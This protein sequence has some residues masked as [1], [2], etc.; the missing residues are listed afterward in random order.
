METGIIYEQEI[1][2]LLLGCIFKYASSSHIEE[3]LRT[4]SLHFETLDN[5]ND[6]YESDY[7][8]T[9][10]FHS[11]ED[12]KALLDGP[13]TPFG[14][15]KSKIDTYLSSLLV[16]CFSRSAFNSLM[17]SHYTNNHHGIC[18]AIDFTANEIPFTAPEMSWGNV[19]YSTHIP[20]IAIFQDNTTEGTL[21]ASLADIVLTKSSDWS[22]EQEVRFFLRDNTNMQPFKP[23]TLKAVIIGRRTSDDEI[24]QISAIVDDFN[25]R[26]KTSVRVL[27]SMRVAST[28]KVGV[29]SNQGSREGGF[30]ARIPV[31]SDILSPVITTNPNNTGDEQD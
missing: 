3:S 25:N 15:I 2:E 8:I 19:Q 6:I 26:N 1:R 22:Y 28:Y 29:C 16:T 24:A 18:Y 14:N 17:W 4:T 27:F 30:N 20:E 9:H 5:Y 10:Y 13:V 23:D 21:R 11:I 12:Q 7:R 31:L